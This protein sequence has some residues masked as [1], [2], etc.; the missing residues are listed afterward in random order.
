MYGVQF[1]VTA[2]EGEGTDDKLLY[3]DGAFPYTAEPLIT[4][5]AGEFKFCP[6]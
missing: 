1:G 3:Q 4:D 2:L 6:L 5:T